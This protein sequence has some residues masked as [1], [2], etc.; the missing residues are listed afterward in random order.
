MYDLSD[1]YIDAMDVLT[2]RAI[3]ACGGKIKSCGGRIK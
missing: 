2:D 1:F 3:L